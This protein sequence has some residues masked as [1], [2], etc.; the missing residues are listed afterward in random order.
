MV[1]RIVSNLNYLWYIHF[2]SEWHNKKQR[3]DNSNIN[4]AFNIQCFNINNCISYYIHRFDNSK[5]TVSYRPRVHCNYTV[6]ELCNYAIRALRSP[7]R[8]SVGHS[9][10]RLWGIPTISLHTLLT[11]IVLLGAI[12]EDVATAWLLT[13]RLCWSHC[14]LQ[15]PN[16]FS[17]T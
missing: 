3:F 16:W 4:Y 17:D 2:A 13:S 11:N 14:P 10:I 1:C 12:E 7:M 15:S 8:L 9:R 6:L 5:I